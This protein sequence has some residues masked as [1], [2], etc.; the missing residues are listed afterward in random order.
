[1]LF[2]RVIVLQQKTNYVNIILQIYLNFK[3]YLEISG[4]SRNNNELLSKNVMLKEIVKLIFDS[5]KEYKN[6]FN[7]IHYIVEEERESLRSHF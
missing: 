1:M 7:N 6:K 2:R 4:K 3:T 5:K